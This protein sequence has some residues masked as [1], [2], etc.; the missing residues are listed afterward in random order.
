MPG[1]GVTATDSVTRLPGATTPS[2]IDAS[3]A[4]CLV[5][6]ATAG[7]PASALPCR[8]RM[9]ATVLRS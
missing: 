4:R 1:R 3:T 6:A 9:L 8:A 2:L 5:S 7:P